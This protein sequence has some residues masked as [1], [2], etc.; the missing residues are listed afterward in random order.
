MSGGIDQ[1]IKPSV[2]YTRLRDRVK[3][4]VDRA[5]KTLRFGTLRRGYGRLKKATSFLFDDRAEQELA[6]VRNRKSECS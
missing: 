6:T 1:D 4:N 3:D 5:A 2:D